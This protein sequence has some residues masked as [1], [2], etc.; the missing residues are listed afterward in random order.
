MSE[1]VGAS[2]VVVDEEKKGEGRWEMGCRT[3]TGMDGKKVARAGPEGKERREG[4][5]GRQ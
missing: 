4:K 3:G 5:V 1:Q 2:H